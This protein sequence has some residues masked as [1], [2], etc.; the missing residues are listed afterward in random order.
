MLM[1]MMMIVE[2]G[3]AIGNRILNI[4]IKNSGRKYPLHLRCNCE[5]S[6]S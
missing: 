5:V 1:M 4:Q 3:N 6:N 2:N